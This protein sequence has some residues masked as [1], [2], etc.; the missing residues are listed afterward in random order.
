MLQLIPRLQPWD[1]WDAWDARNN[2]IQKN[3]LYIFARSLEDRKNA[4]I[5]MG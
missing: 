5:K 1:A 4:C 2:D 3:T